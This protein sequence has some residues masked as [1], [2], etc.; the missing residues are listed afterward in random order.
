MNHPGCDVMS[1][2]LAAGYHRRELLRRAGA[3]GVACAAL[4][5]AAGRG[6]RSLAHPATP[7]GSPMTASAARFANVG[8]YTRG[9]PGVYDPT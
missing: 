6:N 5:A 4:S 3:T 9:A 8:S 7:E 2:A 1:R